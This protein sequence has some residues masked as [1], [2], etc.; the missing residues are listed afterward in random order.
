MNMHLVWNSFAVI[1]IAVTLLLLGAGTWV[2]CVVVRNVL[3]SAR[4]ITTNP[5]NANV[6]PPDLQLAVVDGN[7]VA[8]NQVN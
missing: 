1:G 4:G 5:P 6:E 3:L 2:L 7:L 8:R